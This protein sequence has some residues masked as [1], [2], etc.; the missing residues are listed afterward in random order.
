M[1]IKP[2]ASLTKNLQIL[3]KINIAITAS[4][5]LVGFYNYHS[6]ANLPSGVDFK[7]AF[8]PSDVA[9]TIVGLL[10]F[11]FF[12]I[13]GITF[14]RWIHRTNK[15][16][17]ALSGVQLRFTSGWS[18]GW[19]FI[20][21][22]NLFKPYQAMKELWYVSHK[23]ESTTD[24][25]LNRWW[26]LW[27]ISN[28]VGR[29]AFKLIMLANDSESYMTSTIAYMVSD[30]LDLMLNIVALILVTRIGMAY[31]RNIIE[32]IDTPDQGLTGIPPLP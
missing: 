26:F 21:I 31:S 11:I 13:L 8:L 12:I 2:L 24:S 20:P 17:G 10:Q 28:F 9:T 25:L 15:N 1:I 7:E 14:L 23:N 3:L 27:I 30:G 29:L 32:K 6:Y 5:V 4:A 16:I 18:V 19:Y 22:A